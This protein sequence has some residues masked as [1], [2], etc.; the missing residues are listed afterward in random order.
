[1]KDS[2]ARQALREVAREY[3]RELVADR[4]MDVEAQMLE[5]IQELQQ[6]RFSPGL[7]IKEIA[8]RFIARHS[9]D[10]E[11]KITPHWVGY[12]IRR[13]LGLKTERRHGNYFIAGSEGLRLDRLLEKYGIAAG[14]ED[15]GESGESKDSAGGTEVTVQPRDGLDI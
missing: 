14:R 7:A 3:H 8:E 2:D 6:E 12:V 15:S 9:E 10:F 5:I 4:G 13:K 11:R 1:V